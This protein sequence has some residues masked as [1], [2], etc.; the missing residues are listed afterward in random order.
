MI[1]LV[2]LGAQHR[3]LAPDLEKKLRE[4]LESS[5]FIL[6]EELER[7]ESE[8][9]SYVGAAHGIG[10]ASG[11]AA[12][13]LACRALVPPG[14]EVIVPAATYAATAFA[15]TLAGSR[16]RFVDVTSDTGAIDPDR[17]AG[18]LGARTRAIVAVHLFGHPAPMGEIL[19]FARRHGLRVIEDCAQAHGATYEGRRV[20]SLGDAGCFSFYPSKNLGAL[21]DGGIVLTDDPEAAERVRLLRHLGQRVRNVHEAVAGNL[22]LDTLQAAFLRV[23][24]PSLD[25]WN[26]RRR[27]AARAYGEELEGS[28][29]V[30]PGARPGCTHVFHLYVIRHRERDEVKRALQSAGIGCGVYYPTPVPLQPAYREIG[31]RESDFPVAVERSR[32]SLALP[33]YPEITRAQIERVASVVRSAL[34]SPRV[35]TDAP[36]RASPSPRE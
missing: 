25:A 22:R 11:T 32:D 31:A 17:L 16:P 35:S 10:V 19:A 33:I 7:F 28:G 4:L 34:S 8:F 3:P 13:E 30:L 29:V 23:K 5:Q 6:G 20:G 26:E 18:A 21:G 1:P 15:V 2:D 24:L 12:L 27:A 9:V 14:S 36:A